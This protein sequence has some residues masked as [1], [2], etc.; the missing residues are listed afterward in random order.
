MA[1]VQRQEVRWLWANRLALGA[2]TVLAAEPGIG[3][4]WLS[5]EIAARLTTNR[6]LPGG[7]ELIEGVD[8]LIM[9]AEDAP[10]TTI[11]PRL[12]SLGADMLRVYFF[13]DKIHR[14]QREAVRPADCAVIERAA[15]ETG[16][17]L[18]IIDSMNS[19]TEGG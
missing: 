12:Q 5:L 13:M 11:K 2:M 14:G 16:A 4:S 9:A 6:E 19:F 17:K 10:D 3:K 1:E 7:P 8:V 18:L 15:A